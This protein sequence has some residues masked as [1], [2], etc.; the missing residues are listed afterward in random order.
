M[1]TNEKT[2]ARLR[3]IRAVINTDALE[4]VAGIPANTIGKYWTF[5][6]GNKHGK[7]IPEKHLPKIAKV[8]GW[9]K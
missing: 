7:N 9:D 3:Q 8:F 4:R 5:L 2:L 6:D 1:T